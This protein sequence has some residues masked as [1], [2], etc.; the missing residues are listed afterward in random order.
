M[1]W[2]KL[3]LS[4]M[5][6]A[7]TAPQIRQQFERYLP[8][9]SKWIDL[10][11]EWSQTS[12]K[13]I[14]P[15]EEL[16]NAWREFNRKFGKDQQ[17]FLTKFLLHATDF[18]FKNGIKLERK[19]KDGSINQRFV[20]EAAKIEAETG[21]K[22]LPATIDLW[23]KIDNSL[24]DTVIEAKRALI[25]DL[26]NELSTTKVTLDPETI[27]GYMDQGWDGQ[28]IANTVIPPMA[29][30]TLDFRA[31]LQT[32]LDEIITHAENMENKNFFPFSRFGKHIVSF[33]AGEEGVKLKSG[34]KIK[35][36]GL[37]AFYQYDSKIAA[38]RDMT[39]LNKEIGDQV[40]EGAVN[41]P[42]L[43][44]ME[45]KE[46][47]LMNNP[48]LLIK[49][50]AANNKLGLSEWQLDN[51]RE[52]MLKYHPGMSFLK[53]LQKRKGTIGYSQD[54]MRAYMDY[55]VGVSNHIGRIKTI[56][57]M[58]D[59][60]KE[61][62]DQVDAVRESGQVRN[63]WSYT[64]I[65]NYVNQQ[66]EYRLNPSNDYAAIR[67]LAFTWFLGFNPASAVLNMSQIPLATLPK[68]AADAGGL[69]GGD[70]KAA[71][72]LTAAVTKTVNRVMRKGEFDKK[73]QTDT[74]TKKLQEMIDKGMT[75]QWLDESYAANAAGTAD[76]FGVMKYVPM[77]TGGDLILKFSHASSWMFHHAEKF[78][79]VVSATAAFDM[80]LNR[81]RKPGYTLTDADYNIAMDYAKSVVL[82]TQ[83]EYAKWARAPF[84][85]GKAAVPFIFFSYVQGMSYLA[86][87]GSGK[88]AAVRVWLALL[89]LAG[90]EGL[91]WTGLV[92]MIVDFAGK[93]MNEPNLAENL[94]KELAE[95]AEQIGID[96]NLAMN[97][98]ASQYGLGPLHLLNI[99]A[100]GTIPN[101]DM[102]GSLS[103][104]WP[105]RGLEQ[106]G[107][108]SGDQPW[109]AVG[110]TLVALG[111]PALALP[112]N[113]LLASVADEPDL[114]KRWEKA[115]PTVAR[116]VSQ[117]LRWSDQGY[118]EGA[119]QS[120]PKIIND[121]DLGHPNILAKAL[122]FQPAELSEYWRVQSSTMAAQMYWQ[123]KRNG[124]FLRLK[125]AKL[126][127]DAE[128]WQRAK[129]DR[130]KFNEAAR[131]AG[132]PG[133]VISLADVQ[134][135]IKAARTDRKTREAGGTT[136][137]M[138]EP[139][140]FDMKETLRNQ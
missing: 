135:S 114:Q 110:R 93:R 65:M 15:A 136:Q 41:K 122:G 123:N 37:V 10:N 16:G 129:Q 71:A 138:W 102:S 59:M 74:Y 3:M 9:L 108:I 128:A 46:Y 64:N 86:F 67:G 68:L 58:T 132:L 72:A 32:R 133:A 104:K 66:I 29:D 55:F 92:D 98:L 18:S 57:R 54:V 39:M 96:P 42:T 131:E 17:L 24:R 25:Y 11:Y 44:V 8:A 47:A 78:N 60:Q 7:M 137:K 75:E 5:R 116:N 36:G 52:M 27:L 90:M 22:A 2:G 115:M 33:Y 51:L 127:G 23:E 53:H 84:M 117:A 81:R 4:S 85:R 63:A 77:R 140:Y 88:G 80:E 83:F 107:N 82:D 45:D 118:I 125:R 139:L 97:G 101:V 26:V 13:I 49:S 95:V 62:K 111:G 106:A 120:R 126:D 73:A 14:Q 19:N 34:K 94:K 61:L 48:M 12:S 76:G 112:M 70:V 35:A 30:V 20:D 99:A 28:Q 119:G 21:A 56:G 79:R 43:D 89:V 121:V 113:I 1:S 105:H 134:K 50:V 124:V 31:N 87:G 69:K 40:K 38:R 6:W 130:L 109:D 91:P 100:P 103:M